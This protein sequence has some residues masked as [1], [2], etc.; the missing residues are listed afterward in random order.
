MTDVTYPYEEGDVTVLGPEIFAGRDDKGRVVISWQ[1]EN[2]VP[3][4][5]RG[6]RLK[7]L[8]EIKRKRRRTRN[9]RRRNRGAS[10]N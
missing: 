2:F 10:L 6:P 4:K 1:G 3:D 9:A 8:S 5:P 7:P